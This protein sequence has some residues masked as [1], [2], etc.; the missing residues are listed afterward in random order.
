[1]GALI[2]GW[3]TGCKTVTCEQWSVDPCLDGD[4]WQ[5]VSLRWQYWAH[6]SF[7]SSSITTVGLSTLSACSQMTSSR[8]VQSTCSKDRMPSRGIPQQ[9]PTMGP[10]EPREVQ[11]CHVQSLTHKSWQ[12]SQPLQVGEWKKEGAQPCWK[13]LGHTGS[14]KAG[15][16]KPTISW[17]APKRAWPAGWGGWFC[18]STQCW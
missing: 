6:C 11:Q 9:A 8:G 14:Q 2:D 10:G 13:V 16:K 5:V 1:M 17:A 12:P 3:G 18:P 4:Q 15:P 7:I